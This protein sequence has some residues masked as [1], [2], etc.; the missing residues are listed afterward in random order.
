MKFNCF[1]YRVDTWNRDN[2]LIIY[3][4]II[5]IMTKKRLTNHLMYIS[6]KYIGVGIS[7]TM[8]AKSILSHKYADGQAQQK[9]D[10]AARGHSVQ[11]QNNIYVK[12]LPEEMAE[13]NNEEVEVE[14]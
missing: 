2:C 12:K 13:E 3:N 8:L 4:L 10:A 1:K 6:N 11:I 7:T 9:K 14:E 5:E